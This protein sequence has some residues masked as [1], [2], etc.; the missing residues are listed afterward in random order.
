MIELIKLVNEYV[1]LEGFDDVEDYISLMT[2]SRSTEGPTKAYFTA[3]GQGN[4]N[5]NE[6]ERRIEKGLIHGYEP[7]LISNF[8]PSFAKKYE[9]QLSDL[10]S[11]IIA[12]NKKETTEIKE[13]LEKTEVVR[14][15]PLYTRKQVVKEIVKDGFLCYTMSYFIQSIIYEHNISQD[16]MTHPDVVGATL[17]LTGLSTG[18]ETMVYYWKKW[19]QSKAKNDSSDKTDESAKQ[20]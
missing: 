2:N 12:S 1:E 11:K 15:E 9:S 8:F 16:T 10:L 5:P 20:L 18:L 3:Y 14:E 17:I 6:L 4:I 19:K 13:D 7:V